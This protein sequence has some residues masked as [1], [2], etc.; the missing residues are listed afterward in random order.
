MVL[1][2]GAKTSVGFRNQSMCIPLTTVLVRALC[3]RW[4]CSIKFS[5]TETSTPQVKPIRWWEE[6][7]EQQGGHLRGQVG[8]GVRR[9]ASLASPARPGPGGLG[10]DM[11]RAL[12][13]AVPRWLS[14][15]EGRLGSQ[16]PASLRP[17][18]TL[19][20]PT[21]WVSS[22]RPGGARK[23]FFLYTVPGFLSV[24]YSG[25]HFPPARLIGADQQV[26]KAM[27]IRGHGPGFW[28]RRFQAWAPY[29]WYLQLWP[30]FLFLNSSTAIL[31]GHDFNG[32]FG[33]NNGW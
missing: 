30:R 24:L 11:W 8:V 20:T 16:T 32:I 9:G 19:S 27:E 14:G 33:F 28:S 12:R 5:L 10:T 31:I 29:Q 4:E 26:S 7:Q 6:L 23:V 2:L 21:Q 15:P 25:P 22:P 3:A 18:I 13:F 1:G 17:G